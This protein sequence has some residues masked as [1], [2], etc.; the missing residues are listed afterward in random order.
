MN[1]FDEQLTLN[2]ELLEHDELDFGTWVCSLPADPAFLRAE[3]NTRPLE[4]REKHSTNT[5]AGRRSDEDLPALRR[6][7]GTLGV[8]AQSLLAGRPELLVRRL[9]PGSE[10]PLA[11]GELQARCGEAQDGR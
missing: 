8:P 1:G 6:D 10:P 3:T 7:E 4:N 5:H 2:N 9:P 11:P